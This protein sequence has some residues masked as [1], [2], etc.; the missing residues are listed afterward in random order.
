MDLYVNGLRPLLFRVPADD[1]H[2]LAIAALRWPLLWRLIGSGPDHDPRLGL[3]L[4]GVKLANP[5]G[6]AP[7]FDKDCD[8]LASLQHLGF[9]F[10][11]PG[12][13]MREVRAGNPR[14]RLGRVVEQQAVI[15]CMGLPSKGRAHAIANLQRLKQRRVPIFAEVQGTSKDEILDNVVAVQ[16]Y[17]EVVEVGL[18]CPNARDTDRYREVSEAVELIHSLAGVRT[19]PVLAKLPNQ[20]HTSR[21]DILAPCLQACVE[22]GLE[23]VVVSGTKRYATAQLS[24]GVGSLAGRPVFEETLGLVREAFQL[25]GD[26][27][28]IIASGGVLTGRDAFEM[29]RAGASAIQ[30]YSAMVYRGW[31]APAL[32][33]RELAAVLEAEGIESVQALV[34][35]GRRTVGV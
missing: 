34:Q 25:A 18:V 2:R 31:N 19:G 12:A 24:M 23:G 4:A 14:P 29:L 7:G 17:A 32:I 30:F 10:L 5:I 22:A 20:H 6:L 33:N 15:N 27:L 13:I 9:G 28:A 26:R 8:V 11:A 3:D 21:H 1:A 16:P 35:R